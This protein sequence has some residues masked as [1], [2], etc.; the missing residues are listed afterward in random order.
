MDLIGNT[1]LVKINKLN[2]EGKAQ[3]IAK[4]EMFNPSGSIKDRVAKEMIKPYI[5]E[6]HKNFTVV[7][8]TSGN[9][10]ISVAMVCAA[11]GLKSVIMC[12][13]GTSEKKI[14][15]KLQKQQNAPFYA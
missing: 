5:G 6:V 9:T 15:R 2:K 7:E 10:G 13:Y 8:A 11:L 14:D 3:I 1:P 4:L 12:P